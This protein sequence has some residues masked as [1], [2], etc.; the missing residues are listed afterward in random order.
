MACFLCIW[1]VLLWTEDFYIS[2]FCIPFLFLPPPPTHACTP[3]PAA[4]PQLGMG[5]DGNTR[6]IFTH[7]VNNLYFIFTSEFFNV[8]VVDLQTRRSVPSLCAETLSSP[9][10][11]SSTGLAWLLRHTQKAECFKV[12]SCNSLHCGLFR[13]R[14]PRKEGQSSSHPSGWP[15]PPFHLP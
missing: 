8:R 11:F 5:T 9:V 2:S 15:L 3:L 13:C 6:G 12:I 10:D 14:L 7:N 1:F 4:V